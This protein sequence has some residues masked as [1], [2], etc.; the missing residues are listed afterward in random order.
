MDDPK[1]SEPNK[2]LPLFTRRK[3]CDGWDL[4]IGSKT[5]YL[6]VAII[7]AIP[8]AV[9]IYCLFLIRK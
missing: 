2:N 4:N 1:E 6:I 7:L 5:S 3:D 9:V 8:F